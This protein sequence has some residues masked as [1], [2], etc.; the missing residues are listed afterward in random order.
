[1][2]QLVR[3]IEIAVY[4]CANVIRVV[5]AISIVMAALGWGIRG[6]AA[7]PIEDANRAFERGD[8][9]TALKVLSALAVRGVAEAR[10]ELGYMHYSGAGVPQDYTEAAKWYR[11]AADQGFAEAQHDLGIMYLNGQGVPQDYVRA[12]MW[13]NLA[14]SQIP[15]SKRT[16]RDSAVKARDS[17]AS[18]MT[19]E[20]IAEAQRLA[21]DWSSKQRQ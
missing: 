12:H 21:H 7:G 16:E 9:A 13:L 20:Q 6:L 3:T 2:S 11:L 17:V 5:F 18:K 8:Y 14:A 1:M 19:P 15:A 4:H 10:Y